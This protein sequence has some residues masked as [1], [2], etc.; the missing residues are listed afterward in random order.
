LDLASYVTAWSQN[1]GPSFCN[2]G[3]IEPIMISKTLDAPRFKI[4][5]DD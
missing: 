3:D 1:F 5:V 4:Q 2:A